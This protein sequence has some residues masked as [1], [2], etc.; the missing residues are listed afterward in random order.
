MLLHGKEIADLCLDKMWSA[1]WA[2]RD[3]RLTD[4]QRRASALLAEMWRECGGF[5]SSM[6][7]GF[8]R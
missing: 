4:N 1:Q 6:M 3:L 5:S 8:L 2:T 7:I